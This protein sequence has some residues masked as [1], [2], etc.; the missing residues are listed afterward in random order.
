MHF[1]ENVFLSGTALLY[2]IVALMLWLSHLSPNLS[3]SQNSPK[4][5]LATDTV[6]LHFSIPASSLTDSCWLKFLAHSWAR[7]P[8]G[9][10]DTGLNP[11][12][13]PGL[14]LVPSQHTRAGLPKLT[15]ANRF[16][17]TTKIDSCWLDA[18]TTSVHLGFGDDD[19][20]EGRVAVQ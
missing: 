9:L 11:W 16:V 17:T 10:E 15:Q 1:I 2:S 18:Q 20:G 19:E 4:T 3:V 6:E 12:K 7:P 5:H 13:S 14:F 8:R